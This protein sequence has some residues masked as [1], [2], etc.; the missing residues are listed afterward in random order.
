MTVL[1]PQLWDGE[2][3]TKPGLYADIPIEVYHGRADLCDGPSISSSGLRTI[4]KDGPAA[5][6]C[7]SPLNDNREDKDEDPDHFRLGKAAHTLFLGEGD[8]WSQ[9]AVEPE[10]YPAKGGDLK[11]WNNNATYCREWKEQRQ[12]AGLSVLKRKQFEQIEGMAGRRPW[13]SDP[14][15]ATPESGLANSKLVGEGLLNGLVEHSLIWR[16]EATG[17]WLRSRPDLIPS[18][19]RALVDLK[20]SAEADLK[21]AVWKRGYHMQGALAAEGLRQV[22]GIELEVFLL[23]FIRTDRPYAVVPLTVETID[24][25]DPLAVGAA[26]NRR[27]IETFARCWEAKCWPAHSGDIVPVPMPDFIANEQPVILDEQ[28][29]AA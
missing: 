16:D 22:F 27:A 11:P 9:F 19:D 10:T 13:Q 5:Y 17:I 21:R 28:E 23:V 29:I 20:T 4:F 1:S 14:S 8:F 3:I 6:W 18:H 2:P 24:G 26:N 12:D 15:A 7:E 25:R